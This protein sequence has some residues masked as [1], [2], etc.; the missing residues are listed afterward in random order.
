MEWYDFIWN[1]KL[2][3]GVQW[4]KHIVIENLYARKSYKIRQDHK[5]ELSEKEA[6]VI[7]VS[8]QIWTIFRK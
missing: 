3:I 4:E 1:L 8:E 7:D 5:C 2:L 6:D